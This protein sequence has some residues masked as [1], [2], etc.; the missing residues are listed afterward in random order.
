VLRGAALLTVGAI[1]VFVV[2]NLRN[3]RRRKAAAGAAA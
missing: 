3:D 2:R 1:A